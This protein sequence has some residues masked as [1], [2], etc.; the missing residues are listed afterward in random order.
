[1][2]TVDITRKVLPERSLAELADSCMPGRC[3]G[4]GESV[5]LWLYEG[6]WHW[7]DELTP[8]WKHVCPRVFRERH[9]P[10]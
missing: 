5:R 1:M 2:R 4:C 10:Q 6:M 9:T 3:A 8:W 7:G